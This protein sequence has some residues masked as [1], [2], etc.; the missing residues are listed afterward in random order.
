MLESLSLVLYTSTRGHWGFKNSYKFTIENLEKNLGR[1]FYSIKKYCNIKRDLKEEAGIFLE[2]CDWLQKKGFIIYN[3]CGDWSHND[4]SHAVGYY[5]DMLST[6]DLMPHDKYTF[7]MEDDWLIH[8]GNFFDLFLV[9]AL[10]FLEKNKNAL[11]V[12]INSEPDK[13]KNGATEIHQGLYR[14]DESFTPYGSTFTFQPTIVRT[15]DWWHSLR[16]I[17]Q[18]LHLLATTHC[19][20]LSGYVFK[21]FSQDKSPFYFFDP[22]LV[23]CEHIG[24]K[25]K[26]E[27]LNS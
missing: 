1:S 5:K 7:V 19:E 13:R 21:Q 10:K 6:F 3:T 16:I 14:Q 8:S 18:N 12:R 11:C 4:S 15:R 27:K 20:L 2:M 26:L 17:N 22:D 24:E 9:Q 25:E 23:W